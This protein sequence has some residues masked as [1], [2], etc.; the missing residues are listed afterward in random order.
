[1]RSDY[2]RKIHEIPRNALLGAAAGV[3]FLCLLVSMA[4]VVNGQVQRAQ[5]RVVQH[6]SERV[7][8]AQCNESRMGAAQRICIQ[9]AI[10]VINASLNSSDKSAPQ[11]VADAKEIDNGTL[12]A[13]Q[14][15]GLL[16]MSLGTRQ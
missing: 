2:F 9:Q 3:L 5:I 12:S 11:A 15:P 14:T 10:A 13:R 7:A 1:M 6:A 8:I 4:L 16:P